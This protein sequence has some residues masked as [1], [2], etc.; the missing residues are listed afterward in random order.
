MGKNR[1]L[2][3]KRKPEMS[4]HD[5]VT[6]LSR[7]CHYL[8]TILSRYARNNSLVLCICFGRAKRKKSLSHL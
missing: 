8:V 3:A 1:W 7:A 2:Q 4:N 6:S 5:R